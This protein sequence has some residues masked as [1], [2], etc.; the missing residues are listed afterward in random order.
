MARPLKTGLEYFPLDVILDDEYELIEAEHG[1]VGFAIVVKL[2][3]RVYA[4]NF[5]LKWDKKAEI[6]FSKR[7][8]ADIKTVSAVINSCMEWGILHRDLFEKCGVLTSSGIQKRYFE[9]IKRRKD[10]I[11]LKDYLLI[12][13]KTE[14]FK[15]MQL[16]N[17]DIN[18]VNDN[19]S[20]QSKV[21][22]SKVLTT[23]PQN[24]FADDEQEEFY[25][26]KKG[27]KLQGS[28]LESF[29][30]FWKA[31][32]YKKDK[33]SAADSWMN[34]P[35]MTDRIIDDICKAAKLEASTRRERIERGQT[36]IYAQGWL[37][38]R[39]W[40]DE[41]APAKTMQ[42]PTMTAIPGSVYV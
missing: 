5:W 29:L 40:E 37:S 42:S 10:V 22:E 8:N 15:N 23:F 34:I 21:K 26:T 36:P 28:R 6:V 2:W 9:I 16:V 1:L 35:A 13:L 7:I 32:D 12:D 19:R 27:R 30:R 25:L 24:N 18:P 39:R 17:A 33:A 20:T 14:E 4:N 38:A 31:F 11:V 41:A 3:Q